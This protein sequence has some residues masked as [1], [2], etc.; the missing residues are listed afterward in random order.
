VLIHLSDGWSVLVSIAAW[1]LIGLVSG[2]V[3]HR[4]DVARFA[5]D[6]RLTRL[7]RW[8]DG[9]KWYQRRLRIRSWK[10]LLPEKG[11]LF[12]GGFSKRHLRSRSDAHLRRFV[13]ETRRAEL[14]HWTNMAAGPFFLI[15][16]RPAIGAW[17]I[18]FG[19][20]VHLPFVL[21]QRYNRGRLLGIIGRRERRRAVR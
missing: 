4:A 12:R 6:G 21:I 20:V 16:C 17:M 15:W 1:L 18:V 10:D 2:Y 11:D 3:L 19:V 14:V 5:H 8:E 13:A 9:G 7:R